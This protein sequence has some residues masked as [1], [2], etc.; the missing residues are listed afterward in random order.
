MTWYAVHKTF[1][2]GTSKVDYIEV[3]NYSRKDIVKD[4]ARVWAERSPG[5][6]DYGWTV[7]LK[8]VKK[9]PKKWLNSRIKQLKVL[10]KEYKERAN[11]LERIQC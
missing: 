6:H 3:P 9:P 2:G 5:G 10:S 1:R 11:Q 4:E 8:R 7:Y